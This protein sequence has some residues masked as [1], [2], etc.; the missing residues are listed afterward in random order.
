MSNDDLT[1]AQGTSK[2]RKALQDA[3]IGSGDFEV[4]SHQ[5]DGS[6]VT[7][8]TVSGWAPPD[9]TALVAEAL[10]AVEGAKVQRS[11]KEFTLR[12]S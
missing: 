7:V 3:E 2:A 1:S 6:T 11:G 9:V 10:K 12:F 4:H 5:E 8:V